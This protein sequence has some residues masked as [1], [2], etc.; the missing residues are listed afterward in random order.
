VREHTLPLPTWFLQV[1]FRVEAAAGVAVIHSERVGGATEAVGVA[2][3]NFLS[4][5][6]ARFCVCKRALLHAHL[7]GKMVWTPLR[8]SSFTSDCAER[9]RPLQYPG[10]ALLVTRRANT[11]RSRGEGGGRRHGTVR[12]PC[13]TGGRLV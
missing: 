10:W 5:C 3:F 13:W 12:C 7:F 1:G 9:C 6:S 4:S 2:A 11:W 8:S